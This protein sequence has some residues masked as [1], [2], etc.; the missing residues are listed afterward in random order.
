MRTKGER[1]RENKDQSDA[2]GS[3]QEKEREIHEKHAE[4]SHSI[5]ILHSYAVRYKSA[6]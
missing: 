4:R 1:E 5:S 2:R 3:A 6:W